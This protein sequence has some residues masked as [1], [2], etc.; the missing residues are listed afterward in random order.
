MRTARRQRSACGISR[1][2]QPDVRG[3]GVRRAGE[4][5]AGTATP[6]TCGTLLEYP[7]PA[8]RPTTSFIYWQEASV[9]LKPTIRITHVA[10]QRSDDATIVAAKQ[11][12]SSHYF[13]TALELRV[14][15]PDP[16]RGAGFWFVTVNRSRSDGLSGFVGRVIRG[17]VREAA[18]SGLETGLIATRG[19][20]EAR[21][22]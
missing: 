13:W 22:R 17:K 14:L 15:V 16:S 2:E 21:A 8:P 11:L 6:R 12:Y 7:K 4:R 20:L 3:Q 9:G 18:R 10:I 19:Y 5:H 1:R